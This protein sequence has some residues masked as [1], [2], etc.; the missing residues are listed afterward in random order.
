MKNE[1]PPDIAVLLYDRKNI[2]AII[3]YKTISEMRGEKIVF[4]HILLLKQIETQEKG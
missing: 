4:P 3:E 2:L 1:S